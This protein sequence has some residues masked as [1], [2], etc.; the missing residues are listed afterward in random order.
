MEQGFK[1]ESSSEGSYLYVVQGNLRS[2][3]ASHRSRGEV[4]LTSELIRDSLKVRTGREKG[5][6]EDLKKALCL[7]PFISITSTFHLQSPLQAIIN[8]HNTLVRWVH[9]ITQV[10]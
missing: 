3:L 1:F 10:L 2:T 5:T 8:L 6:K 9:G 4:T 7:K